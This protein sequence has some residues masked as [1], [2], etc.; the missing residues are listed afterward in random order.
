MTENNP[1]QRLGRGMLYIG[2]IIALGLVTMGIHQW[3]EKRN[4]PNAMPESSRAKGV[5]EVVLERNHQHHYVANGQINGQTVAFLL[6]TGAT[7]V[8]VP[9]HLANK[10][11][12]KPGAP[13]LA[14]TANGVVETRN[15]V[16]SNLTLG[17][18]ELQDVRA[19]IN[20]GMRQDE[21]LLGMSALKNVE[22]THRNGTLTIRQYY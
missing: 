4:N 3:L 19:S 7:H 12:L 10:L 2:W 20:P 15:T 16:I 21:I 8:S 18:I 1:E 13:A 5:N 14:N 11:G 9:R 17:S 6:D 22:F